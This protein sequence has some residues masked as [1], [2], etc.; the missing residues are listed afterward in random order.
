MLDV[1]ED[2]QSLTSFRRPSGDFMKQL[3]K[4]RESGPWPCKWK[5]GGGGDGC[6][7]ISSITSP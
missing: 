6:R 5:S 7:S 1:I 3:R 2:I 4:G